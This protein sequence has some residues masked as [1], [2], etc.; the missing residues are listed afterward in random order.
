MRMQQSNKKTLVF[1]YEFSLKGQIPWFSAIVIFTVF[2][3]FMQRLFEE[4]NVWKCRDQQGRPTYPST[5][6]DKYEVFVQFKEQI[7]Q[8]WEF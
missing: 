8:V 4:C 2:W 1:E 7:K 5:M 3:D 6:T